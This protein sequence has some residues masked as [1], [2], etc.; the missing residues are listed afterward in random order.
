ML[1]AWGKAKTYRMTV[2]S[3]EED[4]KGTVV[5]ELVRPDRAHMK[6]TVQ[7]ETVDVIEIGQDVYV[8]I[9]GKWTKM[10]LSSSPAAAMMGNP[11]A[12]EE[13]IN[14]SLQEGNSLTKGSRTTV[15]GQQCQEWVYTSKDESGGGT[16]CVSVATNLPVQIKTSDGKV[17]MKFSDWN[18]P[19]TIEP[20][21]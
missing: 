13:E 11:Q 20:P 3:N 17:T 8:N 15:D 6:A 1:D 5:M 4:S 14:K 7:G 16:V 19:I 9:E 2:E 21:I 12:T 10:S 18:A